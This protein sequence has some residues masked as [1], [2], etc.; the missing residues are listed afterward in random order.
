MPKNKRQKSTSASNHCNTTK[1]TFTHIQEFKL[2]TIISKLITK[3]SKI[4][5]ASALHHKYQNSN[6]Y[7]KQPQ[8]F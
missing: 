8:L 1:D 3:Y 7:T 5:I 2:Y 4:L 6:H